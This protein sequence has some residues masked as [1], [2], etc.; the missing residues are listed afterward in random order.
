MSPR[1]WVALAAALLAAP[2]A[3]LA[4]SEGSYPEPP[5]YPAPPPQ[6][7][8]PP[9]APS[10]PPLPP[11][12][13]RPAPKPATPSAGS[14]PAQEGFQ[15]AVTQSLAIPMGQRQPGMSEGE[16]YGVQFPFIVDLGGRPIPH[17]YIGGFAGLALGGGPSGLSADLRLGADAKYFFMPDRKLDPWAGLALG[18]EGQANGEDDS[19]AA[20]EFHIMGGLDFRL[21]HVFGVGPFADLSLG[22]YGGADGAVHAWLQ[23]GARLVLFP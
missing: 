4:Q 19:D 20:V 12:P 8:P 15:L 3:A 23:L 21:S 11:P 7:A 13:A 18:Y 16:T 17:L 14:V 6:P 10:P 5:S 1:A 2:A 9:T 22:T